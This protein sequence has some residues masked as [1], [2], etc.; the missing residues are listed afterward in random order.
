MLILSSLVSTLTIFFILR[1][2][3]S[4][5]G[6]HARVDAPQLAAGGPKVRARLQGD[7][8]LGHPTGEEGP[9]AVLGPEEHAHQGGLV[10]SSHYELSGEEIVIS[11]RLG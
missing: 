10:S 5:P 8:L 6:H 7:P 2:L 11:F 4:I 3:G 9:Q 1:N